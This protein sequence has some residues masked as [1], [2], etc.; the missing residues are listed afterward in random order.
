M[1]KQSC[2]STHKTLMQHTR[3]RETGCR[4]DR[5]LAPSCDSK[6]SYSV[7]IDHVHI[8]SSSCSDEAMDDARSPA[9]AG[10]RCAHK[11]KKAK[12]QMNQ[13]GNACNLELMSQQ[14][15]EGRSADHVAKDSANGA[16][17]NGRSTPAPLHSLTPLLLSPLLTPPNTLSEMQLG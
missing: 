2:A 4:T 1:R 6:V 11:L 7:G 16:A 3:S 9:D 8:L 13:G 14:T 10:N 5:H 17:G 12:R 15:T